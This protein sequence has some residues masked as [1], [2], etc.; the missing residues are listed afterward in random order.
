M[1]SERLAERS[2]HEPHPSRLAADAPQ[3]DAIIKAHDAAMAAGQA[4]YMDPVS[5]LFV[6]TAA[7][8]AD[9]GTCCGNDCRHC[10]Y[11]A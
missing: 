8:H 2:L 7:Y 1:A 11:L 5:G 3:R 6:F 4:G 9:R 10:P